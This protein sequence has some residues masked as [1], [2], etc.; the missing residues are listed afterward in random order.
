ML[1]DA[2]KRRRDREHTVRITIEGDHLG[3]DGLACGERAGLVEGHDLDVA[4]ILKVRPAFDED[5]GLTCTPYA[6]GY[7][8]RRGHDQRAGGRCNQQHHCTR[9]PWRNRLPEHRRYRHQQDRRQQHQRGVDEAEAFDEKLPV[10]L[11]LLRFLHE[12]DH[13]REGVVAEVTGDAHCQRAFAIDRAGKD[14]RAGLLLHRHALTG[15]RR[16]VDRRVAF[17]DHAI[18]GDGLTRADEEHVALTQ[19]CR[20]DILL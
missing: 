15:H 18:C 20:R 1:G 3:H 13:A 8:D 2:L 11:A 14:L 9:R 6:C 19:V 12:V 5:A 10:P 7:A 16:L 4:K 17:D